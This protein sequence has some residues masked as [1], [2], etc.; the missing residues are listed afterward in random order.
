MRFFLQEDPE[1]LKETLEQCERQ[2]KFDGV[3]EKQ[4]DTMDL[5]NPF[6]RNT[7]HIRKVQSDDAHV[8]S[9]KS[10]H[11]AQGLGQVSSR[12]RRQIDIQGGFLRIFSHWCPKSKLILFTCQQEGRWRGTRERHES[13][14]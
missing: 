4:F 11:K 3:V 13:V 9:F 8:A 10:F 14:D 7:F 1:D 12:R 5:S 6:Q 2:A